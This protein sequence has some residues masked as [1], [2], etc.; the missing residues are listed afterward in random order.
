MARWN[1]FFCMILVLIVPG[2]AAAQDTEKR[3]ELGGLVTYTFLREIGTRDVGV[4]TESAGFGG[5]LAY[6][7]LP[8]LDLESEINFLPGN[9]ATSGNHVQG[10]FGVKAGKRWDKFGIFVKARPGFMHFRRD[11]FGVGR[12][13]GDF[14][15]NERASSTEPNFDLGGVIEYYTSSGLILRFDLGD[16]VIRYGR[17]TVR[18]SDFVPPFEAGGFTTHNWQGSFGVGVRF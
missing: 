10:F 11:P 2:I 18:T 16:S 12:P 17:R 3:Y 14:F 13:G 9:S 8:F 15:S 4:G 7:A 5:R 1:T 6:R